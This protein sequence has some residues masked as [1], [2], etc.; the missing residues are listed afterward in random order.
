VFTHQGSEVDVVF[1]RVLPGVV[2]V[3]FG[4]SELEYGCFK[5]GLCLVEVAVVPG[6]GG[7][8]LMKL[9]SDAI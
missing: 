8:E 1:L 7:A 9:G 4:S 3:F 5:L 2:A 6:M